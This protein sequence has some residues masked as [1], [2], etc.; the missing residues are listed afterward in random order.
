MARKPIKRDDDITSRI[1]EDDLIALY[2]A[3]E[4][5]FEAQRDR[6]DE[7]LDNW[8]LYNC[9]LSPKQ[10]YNGNSQYALPF[11]HDAVE[12]RVTRFTN[13]V[14][15]QSGRYIEVTTGEA[16]PPQATQAML[17]AYVRK[18]KLRTVVVPSLLRSGDVEGQYTVYVSW[19]ERD[20][21]VTSKV[22][23]QPKTDGLPNEAAE[24]VDDVKE[25]ILVDSFP[26]VEVISDPDVCIQPATVDSVEDAIDLGSVT[27]LRRWSKGK[28]KEMIA[29]GEIN[30]EKGEELVEAMGAPGATKDKDVSKDQLDAAGI[31][32]R[33][34]VALVYEIW[35]KLKIKGQSD[36]RLCRVYTA[37]EDRMLGVKLNPFWNDRCPVLSVPVDRVVGAARGRSP[38]ASCSDLQV[39]ANDTINEAADTSHFSAMPI[40]MTDPLKNP[41]VESMTL[42]LG[43]VWDTNPNDT[44]IVTFPELWK[45]GLDR[46]MALREQIFQTLGVNP[47]MIPQSTGGA[48]K[49]NQAELAMEQQVDLLT[50]AD[51]VTNLEEGIL[52]PLVQWFAELD[53]QFRDED[54]VLRTYGEMGMRANMEVVEPIQLNERFEFR[55]FGVESARNAAQMQ[56]QI[57]F[58]NVVKGLPPESYKDYELDISPMIVMGTENV[59]GPRIAPLIF[60]KKTLISV[61]PMMENDMM[62]EGFPVPTHP[63]DN[64]QEHLQA[65]MMAMQ[66]GDPHQTIAN[67]MAMHMQQLQMKTAQQAQQQSGQPPQQGGGGGGGGQGRGPRPGAT[68]GLPRGGQQPAGAMHKDSAAQHGVVTMPRKT[69]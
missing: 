67:H 39:L 50:T 60:K 17:E 11:I 20:R 21:H 36:R 64:D 61:D 25:E 23:A 7:I 13:Q 4:K 38:V 14:F 41:R 2:T 52:T 8:D 6:A 43:A 62:L 56:S 34:K 28:I 58:I 48:K 46:A 55:W 18:A 32:E 45:D 5:G 16:D 65:H 29:K 33:G 12:A 44:Q 10:F 27:V 69:A 66:A 22:K 26:D 3:V 54:V 24:P 40:V 57:A 53:H 37:G 51:A 1:D 35:A 47:A 31:K 30:K 15:P 42:G 63:I 59:F 9:K 19:K 49:R 68:P